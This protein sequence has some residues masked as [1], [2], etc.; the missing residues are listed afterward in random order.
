MST[1]IQDRDKNKQIKLDYVSGT[2]P[3]YVGWAEP[4]ATM[5]QAKW[6]IIKLT[7]DANNN[8]TS[9]EYASETNTFTKIW[10]D[11]AGYF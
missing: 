2:N 6:R 10:N 8:P 3:I 4:K 7:W 9:K 11:R 1:L 5:A